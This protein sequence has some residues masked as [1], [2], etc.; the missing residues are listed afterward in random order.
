VWDYPGAP[1]I[2]W[3]ATLERGRVCALLE[4]SRESPW[5]N[6]REKQDPIGNMSNGGIV[7]ILMKTQ[8]TSC[9]LLLTSGWQLHFS[10]RVSSSSL[11]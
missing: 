11:I 8:V 3:S 2:L 7:D 1:G 5:S 9:H 4:C 6:S 10:G